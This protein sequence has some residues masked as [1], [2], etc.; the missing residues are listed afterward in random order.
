MQTKLSISNK[1]KKRLMDRTSLQVKTRLA[2]Q[3]VSHISV[4][5]T[6]VFQRV[7]GV[8]DPVQRVMDVVNPVQRVM[9]VVDPVQRV[10][11]M[12]NPV[13][14]VMGVVDP[15]QISSHLVSSPRKLWFLFLIPRTCSRRC[16]I[17]LGMLDPTFPLV[18]G[19]GWH[20]E[21]CPTQRVTMPNLVALGQTLWA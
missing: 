8:V 3:T 20:Q 4:H 7:M 19:H 16:K 6:K 17:I 11:D 10:M 14:R 21:T 18:W 2:T 9:G 5:I 12:V 15:V 13:Q 1:T